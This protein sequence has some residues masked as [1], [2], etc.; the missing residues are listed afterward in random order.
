MLFGFILL[1]LQIFNFL[2]PICALLGGLIAVTAVWSSECCVLSS[3]SINCCA[4]CRPLNTVFYFVIWRWTYWR[5]VTVH[6]LILTSSVFELLHCSCSYDLHCALLVYCH[7]WPSWIQYFHIDTSLHCS[8]CCIRLLP[9]LVSHCE[10]VGNCTSYI[11]QLGY[12]V[13]TYQRHC[14]TSLS[15]EVICWC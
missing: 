10:P 8:L 1:L 4:V 12:C 13:S 6:Y 14:L 9:Q 11:A 3:S 7:M 15:V 2:L 5:L